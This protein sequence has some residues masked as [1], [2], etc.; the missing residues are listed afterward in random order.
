MAAPAERWQ[1]AQKSLQI[2]EN[3]RSMTTFIHTADWQLGKP[4]A[5]VEDFSKR[6]R[7]QQERISVLQR[8]TTAVAD[9]NADFVLVAGDLF[10]STT[11]TR[12]VVSEACSAIGRMGVPVYVI[13]GNHDHGGPGGIWEQSFF[14]QEREQ[15]APNLTVL[16][17]PAVIPTE[18]AVLFPCPLLRRHDSTDT[19]AWLRQIDPDELEPLGNKPR[20]VLAH[21]STQ[22]FGIIQE[23]EDSDGDSVNQ[24]DLSR[25]PSGVFDY[26]ALGDW[27]G[28]KQ[29]AANAWY[30]GTPEVDRFPKG[31]SNRPGN[32]LVVQVTRAGTPTVTEVTTARFR[33]HQRAFRFSEDSALDLFQQTLEQVLE[34]RVGEDL[35]RIELSGSLGLEAQAHLDTI[36]ERLRSRLLRL[37]LLSSVKT[38]PTA[39]EIQSLTV[40]GD[41]PVIAE[42]A[43]TLLSLAEGD[44]E[45][46]QV[47]RIALRELHAACHSA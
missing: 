35:L 45:N 17:N 34:N 19:T 32:I 25:I 22:A 9:C 5:R 41:D 16:L 8:I 37:K 36:L 38:A 30:S 44:S 47:A 10:D 3:I 43:K 21:G 24:I 33:W 29:V 27:H 39:A 40:R 20:I 11:V 18:H 2:L 28:T 6:V 13:P 12:T 46:A 26:V 1:A 4:F 31:D 15:L 23:D 7:L 14:R 42:V